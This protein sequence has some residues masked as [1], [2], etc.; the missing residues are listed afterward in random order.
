MARSTDNSLE[1]L[2]ATDSSPSVLPAAPEDEDD[3]GVYNVPYVEGYWIYIDD[4]EEL[5]TWSKPEVS[6]GILFN[7]THFL[8]LLNVSCLY[9]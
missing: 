9:L 7:N 2:R 4:H 1:G 5:H 3:L 6:G 8:F